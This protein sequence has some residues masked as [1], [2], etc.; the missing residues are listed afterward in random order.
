MD[1]TTPFPR[2]CRRL[3]AIAGALFRVGGCDHWGKP[4]IDMS[5]SDD[6]FK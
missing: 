3:C 6:Q 2:M 1:T 5:V 4:G